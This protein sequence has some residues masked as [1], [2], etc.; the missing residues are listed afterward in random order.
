MTSRFDLRFL[1]VE[2]CR[3][4]SHIFGGRQYVFG[5]ISLQVLLAVKLR[6]FVFLLLSFLSSSYVL[7]IDPL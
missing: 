3:A 2:W 7:D 6:L 4:P 1:D 5:K